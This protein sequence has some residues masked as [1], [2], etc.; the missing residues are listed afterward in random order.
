MPTRKAQVYAAIGLAFLLAGSH[1][2]VVADPAGTCP[3]AS[4]QVSAGLLARWEAALATG[5]ADEVAKLYAENAVLL[6]AVS[7]RPLVGRHRIRA[8]FAQFLLKHPRA[9]VLRR[10]IS[11]TCATAV[12]VG[13]YVY[14]VTGRRKGTRMLI[15]GV[16][17][18][19][20]AFDGGDWRI[21][22]HRVYGGYRPLSN[23][24][25]PRGPKAPPSV[26]AG[27]VQAPGAGVEAE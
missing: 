2:R 25:D 21:V 9:S 27:Q 1:V 18:L 26:R 8:H 19:R 7:Q 23:A 6:P 4:R 16:Y 13:T 20:Y 11:V 15:G 17:A 24:Q 3:H 5:N 22:S 10:A 12:D 14:R